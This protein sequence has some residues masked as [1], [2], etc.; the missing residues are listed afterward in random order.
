ML[1]QYKKEVVKR[2][3]PGYHRLANYIASP[4]TRSTDSR[5]RTVLRF[6]S[7]PEGSVIIFNSDLS[8]NSTS[9][10]VVGDASGTPFV[11]QVRVTIKPTRVKLIMKL[12]SYDSVAHYLLG[13]D[14]K[15][16]LV[17]TT[18]DVSGSGLG[19]QGRMHS[20]ATYSDYRSVG[21][22]R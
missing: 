6:D 8:Q 21:G 10:V 17:E 19:M 16:I 13:A 20:V 4:A 11:E 9:E 5:G 7:L 14:G 15:P 1:T 22:S 2:R 12:N 18:S 3:V